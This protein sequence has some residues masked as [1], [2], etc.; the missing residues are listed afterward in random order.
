MLNIFTSRWD[1]IVTLTIQHLELTLVAMSI[2]VALAVP[3][4]IFLTRHKWLADPVINFAGVMQTIPSLALLGFMIPFLG[5]GPA[6]A[7]VALIIYGLLPIIRNTYIGITG[8]TPAIIEAGVGMGMTGHQILFKIELPLATPV[9]MGGI[10]TATVLMIGVTTLATLVGAG[11]LGDLIFRGIATANQELILAGAIPAALLAIFCDAFLKRLEVLLQ[12][13]TNRKQSQGNESFF[14]KFFLVCRKALGLIVITTLIA[15]CGATKESGRIVVGGK[16]YTEQDIL[17]HL[18]SETIEGNTNLKV[19]R[20]PYLG[21]TTIVSQALD[22]GDLDVYPE[23]T[24]TALVSLMKQ[25][26]EPD[27]KKSYEIVSKY[28]K[29][30]KNIIW[31]TPFGY[32]NTYSMTVRAETADRL[33]LKKISDLA[34]HAPNMILGCTHEFA[35]RPD[36]Y[37]ELG[38][39]YGIKFKEVKVLDPGLTYSATKENKVDVCDAFTTDGRIVA[40][41][42]RVLQDDK[43]FFPDYH[44]VPIVRKATL[45]KYPE[46]A[47]ALNKLGGKLTEKTM[48]Q[49]NAKVDLEK[50]DS[51]KVAVDWL[52]ANNIIK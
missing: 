17:V 26:S 1:D 11:G 7:I 20:K 21:S 32:N 12:A 41:N 44:C 19:T 9:I 25:P 8:V 22:K 18:M 34:A 2:V 15:G 28:Y 35:E 48:Q 38:K 49:L 24:G 10:R 47:T 6:P 5:I 37:P 39:V 45:D 16:N 46:L 36:G 43:Q 4:G 31:L 30:K 52:K 40:F 29:E 50:Q 3:A 13:H 33:G 14:S 23:Y 42:L 51:K 27:P